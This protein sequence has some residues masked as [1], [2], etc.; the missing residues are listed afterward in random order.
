M[1]KKHTTLDCFKT[2]LALTLVSL[3]VISLVSFFA[4]IM[5]SLFVDAGLKFTLWTIG[6]V[7]FFISTGISMDYLEN[8]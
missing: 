1:K 5:Y 4:F 7:L 3:F 6:I 2:A 8:K